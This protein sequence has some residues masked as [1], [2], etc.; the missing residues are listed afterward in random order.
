[1]GAVLQG[2][3]RYGKFNY[4][5]HA[6]TTVCNC[7]QS[8]RNYVVEDIRV[9]NVDFTPEPVSILTMGIVTHECVELCVRCRTCGN[10]D[11]F[12]IEISSRKGVTFRSGRY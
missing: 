3:D 11:N 9:I 7:S 10:F 8:K 1:M 5:K 6:D 2:A 4:G 12:T